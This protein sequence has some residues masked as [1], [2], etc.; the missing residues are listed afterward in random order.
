MKKYLFSF[1]AAVVIFTSFVPL[2]HAVNPFDVESFQR[3]VSNTATPATFLPIP[4]SSA[5][6][7]TGLDGSTSMIT[8]MLLGQHLSFD[9][10][11]NTFNVDLT[12]Q[13]ESNVTNLSTD[14]G[15]KEP[16]ITGSTSDKFWDGLKVFRALLAA[17]ISDATSVGKS[18]LTA[19]TA[20]D[21]RTAIGAGTSNFSGAYSALTG[22]PTLFSGAYTDLT[23]K[24]TLFSGAYSDLTGA[25]SLS[26]VA[27]TGAYSDLTGKPTIPAA[28]VQTDWNASTGLGVLLNKP[29]L[30]TVAT[31]GV[32][33]DLT[34]KPTIPAAQVQ[35]DWNA[36]TGLGVL[37]NKPTI[38][39]AQ[40][41]TDWNASTGL[42]VLL[43]KPA[44]STVATSGAYTDLSGKPSLATV[45][46]SGA[47][48]DLTGKPTIPSAQVNS[49]WNASSGIAQILNKPSLAQHYAAS[50][51]QS[52][53]SAPSATGLEN[54]FGGTT[55]TWARTG[56][57]TYT[58]TA[59][60]AVFTSGKT[61]VFF[62]QLSN[63]LGYITATNTST[64]VI[65]INTQI[66]SLL[67][68][69]LTTG[70]ADGMMTGMPIDI[71]VYQ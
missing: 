38:P 25:P 15:G 71:Q 26:T 48:T 35:T 67:S 9:H 39:A 50:V 64:T 60:S 58:I 20:S 52:G 11:S 4:A 65:T 57:G 59:S 19:A 44:L 63:P 30:S 3:N 70:N 16:S 27:T 66:T 33:N 2:A 23:G 22:A 21:A 43:N 61:K 32:Y 13:P 29:T 55:F 45:A 10:A 36:T 51:T 1:F 34:G 46:T 41:Q 42:G 47:Y 49:D 69:V 24:P 14:L 17:D 37:L 28:Q 5:S 40:I 7:I 8:L 31:S 53:T 6:A 68:L 56:A 18:V 62:G 54:D 12:A